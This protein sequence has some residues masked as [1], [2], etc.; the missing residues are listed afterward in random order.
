M[1]EK[2]ES[3]RGTIILAVVTLAIG[4]YV[5]TYGLQ[6]TF[7]FQAHHWASSTPFLRETPQP[8]PSTA[9]SPAQEKNLSFYGV[10]F[11]APWKGIASQKPGETQSEVQFNSG[12]VIV[13]STRKARKTFCRAYETARRRRMT[14]MKRFLARACFRRITICT[15]RCTARR[16]HR[17]HPS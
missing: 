6:T 15:K 10:N 13:F 14:S 4:V 2:K 8:L 17:F 16:R 12:P 9:A 5:I 1:A 11:E 7:Y 3:A